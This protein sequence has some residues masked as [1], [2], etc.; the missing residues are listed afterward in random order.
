[1]SPA[2]QAAWQ[3]HSGLAISAV[4]PGFRVDAI[5]VPGES[6]TISDPPPSPMIQPSSPPRS[7]FRQALP[8]PSRRGPEDAAGAA[9]MLALAVNGDIRP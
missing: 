9:Y 5:T 4:E 8:L 3:T 1:M 2:E 7:E 6:G